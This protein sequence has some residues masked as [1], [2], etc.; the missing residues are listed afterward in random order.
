MNS[1]QASHTLYGALLSG[2]VG[3]L[4]AYT[5]TYTRLSGETTLRR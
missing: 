1:A 2:L 5:E 3:R 4:T